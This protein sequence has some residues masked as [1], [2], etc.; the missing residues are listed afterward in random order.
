M[1][2][3][4]NIIATICMV[5]ACTQVWAQLNPLQAQY[6][7]NPYLANPAMAGKD[8]DFLLNLSYRSQWNNVPGAPET[9]ALTAEY[10]KGRVGFG[11]NVNHDRAGLQRFTSILGRY[12]YRMPLAKDGETLLH[13]GFSGGMYAE[14][15][16]SEDIQ[17]EAGDPQVV[18]YNERFVNF[19]A[20]VGLALTT[21]RL[22]TELA[23]PNLRGLL[24]SREKDIINAPI[25]YSSL[26][27]KIPFTGAALEPKLV[28]REIKG[29]NNVLDAGAQ[30]TFVEGQVMLNGFY[31]SNQSLSFG[32]VV[33]VQRKYLIGFCHTM[34]T[35]ELSD[36]TVGDFELSLRG[37][38]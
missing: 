21:R 15:V 12:A 17:G 7:V 26:S 4:K 33:D 20:N 37:R 32:L 28:Y 24:W 35:G 27:Y 34:H 13:M 16:S 10:G 14:R 22:T 23:L 11:L 30:F 6:F 1:K 19:E 8:G 18:A 38:F 2:T 9:Q 29:T 31:H 3:L 25:F 36:Y 5:L